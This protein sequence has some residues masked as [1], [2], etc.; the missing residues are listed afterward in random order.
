MN[1]P[2]NASGLLEQLSRKGKIAAAEEVR[3]ELVGMEV[4]IRPSLA[5]YRA[6]RCLLRRRPWPPNRAEMFAN[7]LSLLPS[8]AETNKATHHLINLESALFF[9]S[10]E[11]DLENVAHFGVI[12]SSKGYIRSMGAPVVACLTRYAHPDVSLRILDE[13]IAADGDYKRNKL[14][15]TSRAETRYKDTSKRL[16]SIL[17]RTH[18]TTG[19]PEVA[20]QMAK[21]AHERGFHLTQYTYQYLLGK[22]EADGLKESAEEARAL[23]GRRSLDVAKSRFINESLSPPKLIPPI[24]PKQNVAVNRALAL[25]MLKRSSQSGLPA[26]AANIVPYF[27]IY[28]TG[29]R[30]NIVVNKLRSRA[31]RLS[32]YA[33][34]TVLL[35]E[36][37]H[38]HCRGQFMHVLWV[39]EKYFHVV[40]VPAEDVKRRLWKRDH[41]PPHL[42]LHYWTLPPRITETTFNLP[43]KLWPTAH[44][45]ALVWTALVQLCESEE[46]LF[47]LYDQLLARSAQ[48]QRSVVARVEQ[49]RHEHEPV[50]RELHGGGSDSSSTPIAAP[51]ER[52]DA[53]HFRPFLVAFTFLRGANRALQVLDD[54]QDRGVALSAPILS[55]GAALQARHGEPAAA[56]RMLDVMCEMLLHSHSH[57]HSPSH[58]PPSLYHHHHHSDTDPELRSELLARGGE[59]GKRRVLLTAH[60]AVLRGLLDRRAIVQAQHV[61]ELLRD[62]LGYVEGSSGGGGDGG[63]GGNARTDAALRFLRRLETEGPR[64]APPDPPPELDEHGHPQRRFYPF[65][66]KRDGEVIKALNAKPPRE[67]T[68][69]R[70]VRRSA[71]RRSS[72]RKAALLPR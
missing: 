50:E 32:L 21:R 25:A 23:F 18:C 42:R 70:S 55:A 5:Y 9:N 8:M 58:S 1:K 66:R 52:Y 4:P 65:L 15:L 6:A 56:L 68:A 36:L 54:M 72:S 43:S 63:G 20:L 46:E 37:L 27:N 30:G 60:T 17:V 7:W 2:H 33:T 71:P 10:S 28:K 59:A 53:A 16:W 57:S 13:M 49:K 19:R 47:A 38:H 34:S 26:Y 40:G 69:N 29:L 48:S 61:A 45:T 39:F 35:A 31:Y 14:R 51:A 12:L 22:L 11:L 64:A 62:R 24:S 67:P 41:Y 44:H 3:R